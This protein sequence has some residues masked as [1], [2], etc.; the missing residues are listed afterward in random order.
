MCSV[1]RAIW[2]LFARGSLA[3]CVSCVSRVSFYTYVTIRPHRG[4]WL[5]FLSAETYFE[6]GWFEEQLQALDSLQ[7]VKGR[8]S[9]KTS[10][11]SAGTGLI[12]CKILDGPTA[13]RAHSAGF[14]VALSR[15]ELLPAQAVPVALTSAPRALPAT[16]T[17]KKR[18]RGNKM[19]AGSKTIDEW[20]ELL[21]KKGSEELRKI[22]ETMGTP[23]PIGSQ[24][25]R[26]EEPEPEPEVA[27]SPTLAPPQT[28]QQ[29]EPTDGYRF[30]DVVF[31]YRRLEGVARADGRFNEPAEI[32]APSSMC[33]IVDK[34]TF[35]NEA[36][37]FRVVQTALTQRS[38]DGP[39][40]PFLQVLDLSLRLRSDNN[41]RSLYLPT[42]K[43]VIRNKP[44][45]TT[46]RLPRRQPSLLF[47]V[48]WPAGCPHQ[49]H[50]TPRTTRRERTT[51]CA[52][53]RCSRSL[54]RR[55]P[56]RRPPSPGGCRRALPVET[57]PCHCSL[58]RCRWPSAIL[59]S[60]GGAS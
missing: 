39:R 4:Q 5:F 26:D 50:G 36:K 29:R 60:S 17:V 54:R 15:R 1:Q 27:V 59:R 20:R 12:G 6:Q 31:P 3:L 34:R 22:M 25:E 44:E 37:G 16:T 53:R 42:Q 14:D 23:R 41:R 9:G 51:A 57:A 7:S 10:P 21:T 49:G 24:D 30:E 55:H 8:A 46:A 35:L 2:E 33:F 13:A 52:R 32:I 18:G 19:L 47:T 48:D 38:A 11:D 58:S 40:T 28:T 45:G 43:S 56:R